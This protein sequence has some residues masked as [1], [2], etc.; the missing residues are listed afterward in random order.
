[1]VKSWPWDEMEILH[2]IILL[3]IYY[4]ISTKD[5]IKNF[6]IPVPKPL[7][8]F[9]NRQIWSLFQPFY[10]PKWNNCKL[11][12]MC[13]QFRKKERILIWLLI[14]LENLIIFDNFAYLQRF[15]RFWFFCSCPFTIVHAFIPRVSVLRISLFC[16]SNELIKIAC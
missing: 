11:Y 12:L 1:M 15:T 14:V 6:K 4:P 5:C 9:Q 2:E 13:K 3:S 7:E 10:H 8:N 16:A